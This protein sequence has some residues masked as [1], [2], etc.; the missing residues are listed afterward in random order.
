[1]VAVCR[2]G[3]IRI[4]IDPSDLNKVIRREHHPMRTIEEVVAT[5]PGAKVLP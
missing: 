4:C 5:I 3:K 2:N 1:M